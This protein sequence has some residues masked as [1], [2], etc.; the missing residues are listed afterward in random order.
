MVGYRTYLGMVGAAILCLR[1]RTNAGAPQMLGGGGVTHPCPRLRP[2]PTSRAAV[3]PRAPLPIAS[4]DWGVGVGMGEKK[5][6]NIVTLLHHDNHIQCIYNNS[7]N[8]DIYMAH[9]SISVEMLKALVLIIT[10]AIALAT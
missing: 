10:P 2:T 9:I 6:I 1:V 3:V 5:I 4:I 8:T 7:N